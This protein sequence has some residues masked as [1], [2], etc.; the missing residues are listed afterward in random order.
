MIRWTPHSGVRWTLSLVFVSLT[1]ALVAGEASAQ[2][3]TVSAVSPTVAISTAQT[4]V[5]VPVTLNRIDTT[6]IIGFSIE[7]TLSGNLSLTS[8]TSSITL[9]PF[10]STTNPNTDLQVTTLGPGDYQAD[11][12]TLGAPCGSMATSGTL[13]NIALSSAVSSGTGTLTVVNVRLRDCSNDP[14]PSAI[15]T[16]ASVT[17]D[18]VPPT[19]TVG[20]P[21]GG[22]FW[23]QGS[24]HSITWAATDNA[25]VAAGGV[26]LAFSPD[27]GATWTPIASGLDNTGLY[28]WT[29]PPINHPFTT[30]VRAIARDVNG[31]AAQDTSD[32][33]FMLSD[34]PLAVTPT[35]IGG[36]A[37]MPPIPDPFQQSSTIGFTLERPDRVDLAVY[38]VD[39]RRIRT[40]EQGVRDAGAFRVVWDGRDNPGGRVPPGVYFIRLAVG[41]ERYT[42]RVT[43]LE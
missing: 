30:R 19:V 31:N 8:G 17:I 7:F 28:S 34:T 40:L 20:S 27:S 36:T 15:G 12:V 3:S 16:A 11:G 35:R 29:I 42:V 14:L 41:S 10:L 23:V 43:R 37:L 4:S 22:E 38:G 18:N 6:S 24:T 13:L 39:G 2:T 26:D 33:P 9:G 5:T 1:G 25:G 32:A 21:N